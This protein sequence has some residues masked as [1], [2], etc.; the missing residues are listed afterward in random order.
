ML[1]RHKFEIT[2]ALNDYKIIWEDISHIKAVI[3]EHNNR[4]YCRLYGHLDR[5][6]RVCGHIITIRIEKGKK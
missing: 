6:Y 1:L 2:G 3:S 4:W 5:G